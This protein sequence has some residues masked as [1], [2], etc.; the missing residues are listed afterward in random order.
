MQQVIPELAPYFLAPIEQLLIAYEVNSSL[1]YDPVVYVLPEAFDYNFDPFTIEFDPLFWDP[2][3][4]MIEFDG[5]STVTI[6]P[7]RITEV[8]LITLNETSSIDLKLT[9]VD[10]K[11]YKSPVY[12]LAIEIEIAKPEEEEE[13]E[14]E[15]QQQ[16][17]LNFVPDW[18]KF[19]ADQARK[20]GQGGA[21]ED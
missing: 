9:V 16:G 11:G 1:P 8:D 6:Y 19:Y 3:A 10:S 15:E 5:T 13:E 7:G 20:N 14:E 2:W 18:D 21:G 4:H 12:T 17:G